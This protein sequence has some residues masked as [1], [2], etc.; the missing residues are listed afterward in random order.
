MPVRGPGEPWGWARPP[1]AAT[2]CPDPLPATCFLPGC[3]GFSPG[4]GPR[5]PGQE[6]QLCG[7]G[8]RAAARRG[9]EGAGGR[10]AP[11]PGNTAGSKLSGAVAWK[12]C[13]RRTVVQG[14]GPRAGAVPR[15]TQTGKRGSQ[16]PVRASRAE[17][18]P[19][20]PKP[21]NLLKVQLQ[22]PR[23]PLSPSPRGG[24]TGQGGPR[25]PRG[26]PH[27]PAGS[28]PASRPLSRP[29]GDAPPCPPPRSSLQASSRSLICKGGW[30]GPP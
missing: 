29:L 3:P 14:A 30:Q 20:A 4:W 27:F 10:S 26:Q 21:E 12:D 15:I 7:E 9:R 19:R 24:E 28:R 23:C 2:P 1:L 8:G 22:A 5:M 11:L 18:E 6:C 25:G 17:L 16:R 13:S